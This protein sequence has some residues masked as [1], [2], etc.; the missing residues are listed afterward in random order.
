MEKIESMTNTKIKQAAALHL[1]KNRDKTG[2]FIAEGIRLVE[3]AAE[4]DWQPVFALVTSE[5]AKKE[6][7]GAILASLEAKRCPVYEVPDAVYRKA[8]A[9]E[10]PQGLMLV[11]RREKVSLENIG[12]EAPFV[13][14]LDGVQ[15][16]GNAG[17]ILRT[18][19]AVGADAVVALKGTTDLFADK[20]VRS[21]M[22][23]H[24][25][26]PVIDGAER[27]AFLWFAEQRGIRCAVTALDDTAQ[28]H[29]DANY[30]DACAVVFGNE[31]NG[32]SAEMLEA[33]EHVFIPMRGQA[34][35]LN[36]A[37]AAAVVLYEA[38]RQR[39]HNA[40][41]SHTK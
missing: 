10:E 34:E 36:V 23:S 4:S 13:V 14:V 15:D 26:L 24:F 22:G 28:P 40:D 39:Y 9:T 11:M 35:S 12:G 5:A 37:S 31:G 7:V 29:F 33:A 25:H 3:M 16:P 20:V 2:E 38:F 27:E 8:A 30:R 32:A 41:S 21:A 18:A 17:T 19:D 1:R 6:R